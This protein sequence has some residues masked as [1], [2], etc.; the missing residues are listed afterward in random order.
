MC[1]TTKIKNLKAIHNNTE[2]GIYYD[3]VVFNHEIKNL[4]AIHN[5]GLF[6]PTRLMVVLNHE[7]KELE[8]DEGDSRIQNKNINFMRK[9]MIISPPPSPF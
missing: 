1:S 6:I 2:T 5:T 3:S 8:I 9:S 7:N 4:K